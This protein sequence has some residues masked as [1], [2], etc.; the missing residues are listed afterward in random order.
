MGM[1]SGVSKIISGARK[2]ATGGSARQTVPA[3]RQR[4][5]TCS[6][7]TAACVAD[8]T[9]SESVSDMARAT[10]DGDVL[11]FFSAYGLR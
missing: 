9:R 1:R 5:G 7:S 3:A 8:T 2:S 4:S 6:C 10:G 11:S